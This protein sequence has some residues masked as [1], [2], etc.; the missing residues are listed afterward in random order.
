M[1]TEHR[2]QMLEQQYIVM[3]RELNHVLQEMQTVIQS[4]TAMT[5]A[6]FAAMDARL[7]ELEP[8]KETSIGVPGEKI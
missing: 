6:G 2:L 3:Q 7:I 1:N 4:L 8:A 5:Q